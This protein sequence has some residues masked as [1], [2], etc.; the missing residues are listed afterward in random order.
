MAKTIWRY[1]KTSPSEGR[2]PRSSQTVSSY[3]QRRASDDKSPYNIP[4]PGEWLVDYRVKTDNPKLGLCK[5][6]TERIRNMTLQQ[7]ERA[8]LFL[9]PVTKQE[10]LSKTNPRGLLH[11]FLR[12]L[13][14]THQKYG[15]H[16]DSES[17][18]AE[19]HRKTHGSDPPD[20]RPGHQ[21]E[22]DRVEMEI[23]D[24]QAKKKCPIATLDVAA[25]DYIREKREAADPEVVDKIRGKRR[26]KIR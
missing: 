23:W 6:R 12:E 10:R 1:S 25:R 18:Y 7:K 8:L 26:P 9:G 3:G 11:R 17:G 14:G 4:I 24:A 5:I 22:A 13:I 20:E 2:S 16:V 21:R 19:W 15:P